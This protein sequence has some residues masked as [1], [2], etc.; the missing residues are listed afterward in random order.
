VKKALPE[1]RGEIVL[2]DFFSYNFA[3]APFDL[4]YERTFLCSLPPPLWKNYCKRVK[5]LLKPKGTLVGFF[6]YGKE[7]DPPPYPLTESTAAEIFGNHFDLWVSEPVT[8][9]LAIFGGKEK[10]QEWRLREH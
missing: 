4:V 9:S 2:G 5:A 1:I 3:A 7:S 8:D 6:F 10:W